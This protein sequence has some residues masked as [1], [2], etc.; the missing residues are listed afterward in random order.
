MK[1]FFDILSSLGGIIILSPFFIFIWLLVKLDSKGPALFKQ[2][3]VGLNNKDFTLYKFRTMRTNA[4]RTGAGQ[5]TVG[6]RDPRITTV[7]YYLR[8]FK[9]DEFPQLI[10][11]LKGDMSVVGPRPEVRKY[12]DLYSTEQLKVLTVRPGI[13]DYASI[14]YFKENE[15]LG[16]SSDPEYDYV[17][18]I[19]P[20]KLRINLAY[21]NEYRFSLDIKI[22]FSTLYTI[23][24]A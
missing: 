10:N 2:Q 23:F 24:V 7:G 8:K 16:Q 3:R 17:H 15:I 14:K 9:L 18:I 20:E 5:L 11:V 19:M 21:V 13:T 1:R 4:E 12:V 6:M 22:I